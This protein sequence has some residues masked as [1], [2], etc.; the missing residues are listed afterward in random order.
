[1]ALQHLVL[2]ALAALLTPRHA[3]AQDKKIREY[4]AQASHLNNNLCWWNVA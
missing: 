4:G 2:L 1:M 3:D